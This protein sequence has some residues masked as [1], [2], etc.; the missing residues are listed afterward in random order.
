MAVSPLPV[1]GTVVTPTRSEFRAFA[2]SY[3]LIPVY[4]E[5]M[6]DVETPVTALCKLGMSESAWLLES[7]ENG[8]NLG[9]YSFLGNSAHAVFT[10]RAGVVTLQ[11]NASVQ[12]WTTADPLD[13]LETLLRQYRC[14][15]V[16]GLPKFF[17]GAV[18]YLAYDAVRYM[19]RLSAPASDPLHL[20][21]LCFLLTDHVLIFDHVRRRLQIVVNA[22][23][24][25]NPD[26]AY[27]AALD[28]IAA[29]LGKL[30]APAAA[31]PAWF[32]MPGTPQPLPPTESTFSRAQFV[33]AV[34]RCK[35]YIAAGDIFQVVLSQRLSMPISTEPFQIYRALRSL[36]PSPYLFYL[37]LPELHLVGSSPEVLVQ[38]ENGQAALRPIAGTRRRGNTPAEDAALEKE[39]LADEKERAEHVMLVDLG[40]NDLGRVCSPGSVRAHNLF[41]VERYSHV[42]HLVSRVTGRL[43]DGATPF[44]V[45]RATF[46][47]G[48]VS[49]APKVRAMQIIDELEPV[50]RGPYA[51]GVGYLGYNG[52]MDTCITIRT[53]MLKDH[54]AYVQAGAGIVADSDPDKEFD[55][56]LA[57][58]QAVL[59]AIQAAEV[60]MP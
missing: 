35:E 27:D 37:Q 14:A 47:A 54:T 1:P 8:E 24:E 22:R 15:P 41:S 56:T 2:Q 40:R 59:R 26:A 53:V 49:G 29:C 9:R 48:T 43:F 44:D 39:L 42:M 13:D 25:G 23:V 21:D 30:Q 31:S 32:S 58:A 17:G 19:E 20:P 18:G 36:N 16:S 38:V 10:A 33:A 28:S 3:N 52:N 11:S 6:A 4:T 34:N 51:G 5:I 12:T 57:K 45:L 7:V 55:E 60:N 46:P 50:W